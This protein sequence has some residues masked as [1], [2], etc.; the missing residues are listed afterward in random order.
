MCFSLPLCL[1]FD[2]PQQSVE[3]VNESLSLVSDDYCTVSFVFV[4]FTSSVGCLLYSVHSLFEGEMRREKER[5]QD[6]D[7][8][9]IH[10]QFLVL[11]N[12]ERCA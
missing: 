10:T 12:D 6:S 5:E 8:T 3:R 11:N 7:K 4:F 9:H 1:T 2:S